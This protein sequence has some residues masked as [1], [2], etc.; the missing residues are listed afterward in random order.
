MLAFRK[1]SNGSYKV[2]RLIHIPRDYLT[3]SIAYSY[4]VVSGNTDMME[5]IYNTSD[6]IRYLYVKPDDLKNTDGKFIILEKGK[7]ILFGFH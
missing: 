1:L 3:T 7:N 6:N 4:F 5:Y 2:E